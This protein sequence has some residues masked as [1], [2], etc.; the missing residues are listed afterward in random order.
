KTGR[1]K[2]AFAAGKKLLTVSRDPEVLTNSGGIFAQEKF[3]DMGF[4]MY[5]TA[6]RWDPKYKGAY[7]EMGKLYGN[8]NQFN[9]AV[10]MWQDGMRLYPEEVQFRN[11][12][13]Q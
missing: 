7:L 10:A 3:T 1:K 4:A 13:L 8:L 12:I 2:E 5:A 6:L 9:R 11:L